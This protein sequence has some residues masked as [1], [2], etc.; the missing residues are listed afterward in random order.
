M[1]KKQVGYTLGADAVVYGLLHEKNPEH[2][3]FFSIFVC[4]V[5]LVLFI[6]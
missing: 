4:K 6:K 1:L 5:S 3:F 2:F